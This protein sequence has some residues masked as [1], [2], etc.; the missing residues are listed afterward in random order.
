MMASFY[1]DSSALVKYYI[2][3]SGTEWVRSLIDSRPD[4]EWANSI[5]TSALTWAE[6]ISAFAKRH[7]M[8]DIS[9]HLYRALTA[10]FLREARLRYGRLRVND[11]L[12]DLAVELVRRHP[13]RAYDAV[14]LATA[15]LLNRSLLADELPSLT[16]VS[17]DDVLCE[18]ARAEGLP[19]ENPNEYE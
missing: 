6:V 15:L 1:C 4:D 7:R 19:A 11:A 12:I 18:A 13:L 10:R 2:V 8:G 14:Q 3:E 9:T 17:A 5:F 16:F